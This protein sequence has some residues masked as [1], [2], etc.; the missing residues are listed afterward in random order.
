MNSGFGSLERADG[1]ARSRHGENRTSA[2]V[3]TV[4]GLG[5]EKS[6]RVLSSFVLARIL[7]ERDFG[8]FMLILV[9]FT[10]LTGVLSGGMSAA[11]CSAVS[12]GAQKGREE[13]SAAVCSVILLSLGSVILTIGGMIVFGVD[14]VSEKVLAA[15]EAA[16]PLM[17]LLP[18]IGLQSLALSWEGVLQGAR[19]F[20]TIT[21]AKACSAPLGMIAVI[22]AGLKYGLYG[23]TLGLTLAGAV[24]AGFLGRRIYRASCE[25]G[26]GWRT[27]SFDLLASIG[28]LSCVLS[29]SNIMVAVTIWVGQAIL[30]RRVG[31]EGVGIFGAGNQ[32]RNLVA[33]PA[34]TLGVATLPFLSARRIS[35]DAG[36]FRALA[37]EYTLLVTMLVGSICVF[38]IGASQEVL[39]ACYGAPLRQ[40]W[41]NASLL[42]A[43][44]LV[45]L[46]GLVMALV[47]VSLDEP[48]Y[49]FFVNF[50]WAAVYLLGA[51]FL[52]PAWGY[53]GLGAAT[54]AASAVQLPLCLTYLHARRAL[55]FKRVGLA[56]ACMALGVLLAVAGYWSGGASERFGVAA[57]AAAGGGLGAWMVGFEKNQRRRILER[58]KGMLRGTGSVFGGL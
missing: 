12:C 37:T 51:W 6:G 44:Q 45:L 2:W 52:T 13:F 24:A 35:G 11:G 53:V 46:P 54:L 16:V 32:I 49:G 31:L 48:S 15:R 39:S 26:V 22:G 30:T 43:S 14:W 41:L 7:S 33:L 29:L 5:F 55:E 3:L 8:L 50:V 25:D 1:H 36:G 34:G 38:L 19:L 21:L 56:F 57:L 23:A 17:L 10:T 27:P 28:R 9:T 58:A 47:V 40:G 20:G 42:F 18:A 4:L